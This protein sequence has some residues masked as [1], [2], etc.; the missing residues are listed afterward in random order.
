MRTESAEAAAE[1]PGGDGAGNPAKTF[2]VRSAIKRY[3]D[4]EALS[5]VSFSV[6]GGIFGLLGANGAGKST[7]FKAT[8]GLIRLDGGEILIDG[9]DAQRDGLEVRRRLGYL[10]EDLELYDRLTGLELLELVAGLKGLDDV[11]ERLEWLSFFQLDAAKDQLISGYSLGMRKK[12]GLASALL[13][14]PRLVLLDEPLN[15][16]DTDS[17]R[18]L[19]LRMEAMAKAGT[20]FIVSSHVMAFVERVCDRLVILKRGRAVAAGTP[21]ELRRET[22]F[23]GPFE[24]LFLS[25]AVDD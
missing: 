15:G 4:F 11:D 19:R 17:M 6:D 23:D 21:E 13:G 16:L 24:D 5:E 12:I 8:V 9:L 3:G 2:E 20:T 14:S 1:A 25:L 18:R 22:A 10:P 7:L